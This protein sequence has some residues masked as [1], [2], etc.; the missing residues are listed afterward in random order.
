MRKKGREREKGGKQR[1][2]NR[3]TAR[4]HCK[5]NS[6]SPSCPPSSPSLLSAPDPEALGWVCKLFLSDLNIWPPCPLSAIKHR[7]RHYQHKP[8][9]SAKT[10][11]QASE[12]P[13]QQGEKPFPKHKSILSR[14]LLVCLCLYFLIFMLNLCCVVICA[15]WYV[16]VGAHRQFLG[17]FIS[18]VL[19]CELLWECLWLIFFCLSLSLAMSCFYMACWDLLLCLVCNSSATVF[20]R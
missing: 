10:N 9:T 2:C 18:L 6:V 17:P 8:A 16:Y 13:L 20:I 15:R 11:M 14:C 4:R 7:W 12:C 1:K 3:R 19:T 5:N